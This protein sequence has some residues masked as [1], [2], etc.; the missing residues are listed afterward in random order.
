[1]WHQEKACRM[2][3]RAKTAIS[4]VVCVFMTGYRPGRQV[5]IRNDATRRKIKLQQ[6]NS[7]ERVGDRAR[8]L[9]G[10]QRDG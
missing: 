8:I 5:V 1:M 3:W 2:I 4:N 6:K 10:M 9:L 7:N